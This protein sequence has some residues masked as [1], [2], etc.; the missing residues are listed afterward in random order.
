ML[1]IEYPLIWTS[2]VIDK[3]KKKHGINPEE[4]DEVIF[5]TKFFTRRGKKG[6][7]VITGKTL[8]GGYVLVVVAK[9][10]GRGKYKVIS[11]RHMIDKEVK[12]FNRQ[13]S[14]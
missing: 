1:Y 12:A 2:D 8:S 6:A 11:A 5:S 13:K 3:I 7:H 14:H 9:K 10:P 4:V